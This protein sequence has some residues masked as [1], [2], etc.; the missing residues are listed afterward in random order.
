M[1]QSLLEKLFGF[2]KKTKDTYEEK[3]D[4][5]VKGFLGVQESIQK[6]EQP[7]KVTKPRA[8]RKKKSE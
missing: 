7:K 1:L 2:Y 3:L 4:E 5:Q 8:P 6:E